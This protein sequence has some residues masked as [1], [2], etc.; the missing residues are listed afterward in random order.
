MRFLIKWPC[1]K[2]GLKWHD[3]AF[4]YLFFNNNQLLGSDLIFHKK[5]LVKS[6]N[7]KWLLCNRFFLCVLVIIFY[8]WLGNQKITKIEHVQE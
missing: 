2:I 3:V 6:V 1:T 4:I 8:L 5:L 7:L